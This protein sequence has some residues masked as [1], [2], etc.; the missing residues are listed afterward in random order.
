MILSEGVLFL[1]AASEAEAEVVCIPRLM[2]RCLVVRMEEDVDKGGRRIRSVRDMILWD[3][4]M[5]LVVGWEVG[6]RIHLVDLGTTIS[7]ELCLV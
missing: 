6:R 2:I 5:Y 4:V 7:S 1:E 3:L